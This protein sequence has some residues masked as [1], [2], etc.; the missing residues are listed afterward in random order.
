[1]SNPFF[2]LK[3]EGRDYVPREGQHEYVHPDHYS[4]LRSEQDGPVDANRS[5][6][7]AVRSLAAKLI[8]MALLM[9][10]LLVAVIVIF[11]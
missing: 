8:V 9:V 5:S 10:G 3:A 4:A 1:M 2:R 11:T 7:K 6:S